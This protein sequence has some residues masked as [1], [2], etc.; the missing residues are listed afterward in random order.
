MTDTAELAAARSFLFV[1]GNR[2]ERFDKALQSG[3]DAIVVDLEDSV[4]AAAK[5]AAREA[6]AGHWSALTQQHVPLV[7]RINPADGAS[8]R[9][10]LEWLA[11]LG[12]PAAVMVPKAESALSL[13][14]VAARLPGTALLPLVES[15]AGYAG[16]DAI[17]G[18]PQVLRLVVGHIDFMADT[19]I[20]CTEGEPELLPLRFAVAIAT[21]LHGLAPAV[22]GVT[23]AIDDD[24]L[25]RADTRRALGLGFGAKLCIH[26]RQVA[27]VH[28]ALLPT[29][30]EAAWAERVV[31]ADAAS[32]GAAVQLD[33]RMV[34]L[35]VVL[36]A[37]RTLARL[38]R[39][40]GAE[41]GR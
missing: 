22:D 4:P 32:G 11:G 36:Q 20:R 28:A 38:G 19:G 25:L 40:P 2:P 6:I 34:D 31:A 16:V 9:Q 18:A 37:R 30:D 27:V 39:K 41:P 13:S 10:D 17:A 26:P 12:A 7:L 24:A 8:G 33:G 29:D 14:Q 5:A 3:A 23:V 21:R 35:P 15:A 1:P